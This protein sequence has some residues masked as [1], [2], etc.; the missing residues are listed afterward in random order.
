MEYDLVFWAQD[1]DCGYYALNGKQITVDYTD[2]DAN[3]D[4][5][6]AFFRYV[7]GFDPTSDTPSFKLYRP[8]AQLNAA[9]SAADMTAVGKNEVTLTTSTVTVDTYT[10]FDISTGDVTGNKSTVTFEATTMPCNLD[11]AEELKADYTYVS[12][13]YLLVPKIGMVSNVIYTFNATKNGGAFAFT[14]TSYNDVPLKQNFRTNILGA[15]LPL[16]HSSL[17]RLRLDLTSLQRRLLWMLL[18]L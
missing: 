5:R 13:N 3:D 18:L 14:G 8:F 2:V 9:V 7:E 6:D 4:T 17:L 16:R 10:G 11:P 12:M 15:L 1:K